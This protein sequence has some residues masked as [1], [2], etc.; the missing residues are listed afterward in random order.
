M[1]FL[2][3]N[4]K[5]DVRDIL[6]VLISSK[7]NIEIFHAVDGRHALEVFK[8]EGPFDLL[9]CGFNMPFQNGADV[10]N[11]VRK[12]GNTPFLLTS[13]NKESFKKLST[14]LVFFDEIAKPFEDAVLFEKIE[15]LISHKTILN[16]PVS[17]MPISIQLLEKIEMPGVSI[18]I[19]LKSDQYVKVLNEHAHFNNYE[20]LRF[21]N[22]NL[23]E[24]YI[25][26]SDVKSLISNFRKNIFSK[27]DWDNIDIAEAVNNLQLDWS[28]LL[29]TTKSFGWPAS[30]TELAQQNIAR[31]LTLIKKNVELKSVLERLKSPYSKNNISEHCYSLVLLTTE[32]LKE[33]S[34]N[35][36]ST[37][38]K[39]TFACLLHDMELTNN[40]FA[41][42]QELLNSVNLAS[43][44]NQQSNYKIF[45]HP[46]VAAQFA[47]KWSSCPADVDKL[48]LQHHEKFDGTGFPQK[49]NFLTIFPLAAVF[50]ISEDLIYQRINFPD[51][52]LTNFLIERESYYNRGDMKK[53]FAA[54]LRAIQKKIGTAHKHQG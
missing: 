27:A 4:N 9:L 46:T 20:L 52:N 29:D 11:E 31:T 34:W 40:L 39:M 33:L 47:A 43:E 44:L 6:S 25:E 13:N 45:N 26:S 12:Y 24:L 53:I 5:E 3:V 22:K 38:Q 42:K 14:K 32:I 18:Y 50:I 51:K 30:V 37:L 19:K 41:S 10:Y 28:L 2:I 54:A 7:Y 15:K 16:P 17:Y 49:L 48:I 36:E 23:S 21:K 35:S 8:E 1:K